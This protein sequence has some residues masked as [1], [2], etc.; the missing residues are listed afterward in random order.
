[1]NFA[2]PCQDLEPIRY[3]SHDII[4]GTEKLLRK[5]RN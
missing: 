1:M 5:N 4:L 2:Q 3:G